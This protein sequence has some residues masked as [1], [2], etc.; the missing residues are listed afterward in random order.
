MEVVALLRYVSAGGG[1]PSDEA[2]TLFNCRYFGLQESLQR[3]GGRDKR[4]LRSTV[5][6]AEP[7]GDGGDVVGHIIG[8]QFGGRA[9]ADSA[10]IFPQNAK[11]N[12]G[13]KWF[14][15]ET[16]WRDAAKDSANRVCVNIKFDFP[17]PG[18]IAPL[19]PTTYT[20]EWWLNGK[21]M[22]L[23]S[24]QNNRN[25]PNCIDN[26]GTRIENSKCLA[27][28]QNRRIACL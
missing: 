11:D 15:L 18:A 17:Q 20:V 7:L 26:P 10:N 2:Q 9:E 8:K 12:G 27:T 3:S 25:T 28:D 16:V 24:I 13:G 23:T 22:G 4:V 5:P 21:Y 14:T 6:G 19:R 1:N